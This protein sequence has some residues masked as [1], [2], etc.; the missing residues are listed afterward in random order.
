MSGSPVVVSHSGIWNPAGKWTKDSI[1]GTTENLLGVY[2]GR[3]SNSIAEVAEGVSDIG[4]VWKMS[5]VQEVVDDSVPGSA[6][7]DILRR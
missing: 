7:S 6:L 3:M 5:A 4:I 1:I 2:S